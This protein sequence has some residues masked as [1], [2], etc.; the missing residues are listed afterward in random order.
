MRNRY[1]GYCY[2]C[3]KY[4]DVGFGFFEKIY[5]SNGNKWR[6]QCVEC[7]DGRKVK[8]TDKE[9]KRAIK[10]RKESDNNGQR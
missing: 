8:S 9:V 2:K 6:I 5:G 10:L 1:P 4:V 7:C 3:G